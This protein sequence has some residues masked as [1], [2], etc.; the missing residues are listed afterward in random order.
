L[1]LSRD[2][3]NLFDSNERESLTT[4][5]YSGPYRM[6]QSLNLNPQTQMSIVKIKDVFAYDYKEIRNIPQG[7][8]TQPMVHYWAHSWLK[9]DY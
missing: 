2:I 1:N 7:K 3:V 9:T 4:P 6:G 5:F 8:P